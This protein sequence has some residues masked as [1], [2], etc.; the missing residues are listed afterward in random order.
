MKSIDMYVR[1][2]Q[3]ASTKLMKNIT[4]FV[5]KELKWV[6]DSTTCV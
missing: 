4:M 3:R 6:Q 5:M 2:S 1:Q